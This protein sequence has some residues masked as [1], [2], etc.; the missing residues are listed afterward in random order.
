MQHKPKN[1]KLFKLYS[2]KLDP[3]DKTEI[4][5]LSFLIICSTLHA[6]SY[7]SQHAH[8]LGLELA[9][10]SGSARDS[11]DVLVG[12][13]FYWS[14]VGDEIWQ[15]GR[16]PFAINSKLDWLLSGPLSSA[17]YHN[18]TSTNMIIFYGG[19]G[20]TPTNENELVPSLKGF[21][22]IEAVGITDVSSTQI[23]T[24]QSLDYVTCTGNYY[25]VSLPWKEG[26]L[27]FSDRYILSL[28][29]LRSLHCYLLNDLPILNEYGHILQDQLSKGVFER[30]LK[31][32][33]T[34]DYLQQT[35]NMVHYL[36]HHGL[37]QQ[38]HNKALHSL[39]WLC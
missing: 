37:V 3:P 20:T 22:E 36:L 21:W 28:N 8:L 5:A 39:L 25:E 29:R 24:D 34:L 35:H 16:G 26:P 10:G 33:V 27:S 17:N 23:S 15:A 6:I 12:S 4:L 13:D 19:N 14:F 31:S 18:I 9:D 32:Q 7:L 38:D 11:I 1:Y 30:V 2:S